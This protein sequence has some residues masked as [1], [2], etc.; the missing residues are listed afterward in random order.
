MLGGETRGLGPQEE[1]DTG[2]VP[3]QSQSPGSAT[4]VRRL[5]AQGESGS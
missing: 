4:A 5:L 2:S 3:E 1:Q